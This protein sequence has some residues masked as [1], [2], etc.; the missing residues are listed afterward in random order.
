MAFARVIGLTTEQIEWIRIGSLLHD[1][2][3]VTVP[4]EIL[5]KPGRLNSYE[6]QMIHEH[7]AAGKSIL[8]PVDFPEKVSQIV[9]QHHEWQD[10]HG[11]PAG[12][13][14]GEISLEACILVVA[15]TVEAMSSHRP[16]REAL[17][18]EKA[19]EEST[20]HSGDHYNPLVVEGCL[21]LFHEE[22]FRFQ[23]TKKGL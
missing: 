9:L 16:Y 11:Y 18:A 21:K 6:L 10:G 12:L 2:G 15:D 19:I 5:N 4:T 7:P 17:G 1:I 20:T 13:T 8:E 22:H 14:A 3:K 23:K